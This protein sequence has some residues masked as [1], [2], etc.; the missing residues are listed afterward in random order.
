MAT[1]T[2]A[3]EGGEPL[4]FGRDA[5]LAATPRIQ[6]PAAA[7]TVH[8]SD[9]DRFSG[10]A[11]RLRAALGRALAQESER[12][13]G[14]VV[15]PVVFGAG[16]AVNFALPRDP[17][18]LP[19]VFVAAASAVACGVLGSRP[20]LR[21]VAAGV[22]V[23]ALGLLAASFE[24]WRAGTQML[25]AD[26]AT[27]ITGRVVSIEDR[28]ERR[29]RLTIDIIST[30]RPH[31]RYA[32]D[33][34]RVTVREVPAGLRAGQTITGAV[35]L[36]PA[37]GPVR[38]DSYDFSFAS[39]FDGIGASGFFL[40]GPDTIDD[41]ASAVLTARLSAWVENARGALAGHIRSRI[42]GAEGDIAAALVA[43][44]QSSIPEDVIEALRRTGLAHFL[45]IS[46]LHMALVAGTMLGVLRAAF[47][48]FPAFASRWPVKKYAAVAAL[49]AIS[50]YLVISGAAVAAQRSYLMFA[51]M[52]TAVVFD[53]AAL[54]MRNLAIAAIVVLVIAPHEIM[55]P[56][57]QM[58]FAATAALISAYSWF[59]ERQRHAAARTDWHDRWPIWRAMRTVVMFLGGLAMTSVIA[60]AAT[61]LF[62]AWH[63]ERVAPLGLVANLLA[64]P[65]AGAVVMPM[66]VIGTL[67]IPIGID[68]PF[69]T[70][71][72]W[73]LTWIIVVAKWVADISPVD[74][75]GLIPP[76]AV[77]VLSLALVVLTVATT[78]LRAAAIPMLAAGVALIATR[79]LPHVLLSEDGRLAALR[80]SDGTLAVNRKRPSAFTV[81]NWSRAMLATSVARPVEELAVGSAEGEYPFRCSDGLCMART[82][83][84]AAVATAEDADAA[85]TVC[86][87]A[88][89][90]LIQDATAESPC[91][92][93]EAL[94][95]TAQDLAR[96]GSA[97]IL[98]GA[99]GK[100]R[101]ISFAVGDSERPWHYQRRFSREARGLP[102]YRREKRDPPTP[103][104]ATPQSATTTEVAGQ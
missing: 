31:L 81:E 27:R 41:A 10:P 69:F 76:S 90:I 32:P 40:S 11:A 100:V 101:S 99:G 16:A 57:F 9:F 15:I 20:V 29:P 56:S 94:V 46:G 73:G 74:A 67:S 55:G 84:G 61:G 26:I 24:I 62:A 98:F 3:H 70:A 28:A 97:A 86:S 102:P 34:V 87:D 45:S 39:Y 75:V 53:R 14:F 37:T 19:I 80:L 44:V 96:N 104:P 22:L 58:S 4:A 25:G 72:G 89:L 43:G 68:Q 91:R 59:A 77:I 103:R 78:W 30:E 2:T 93:G 36:L 92:Y 38:P 50:V 21:V 79:E 17:A 82:V 95:V 52:L 51:V 23:F 42:S 5:R 66:A 13:T 88:R 33:R 12:G 47:A 63:F 54:T 1:E 85:R 83:E 71:M 7:A 48:L 18:V 8:K 65:I 35:R 49:A 6:S 64:M 60:G